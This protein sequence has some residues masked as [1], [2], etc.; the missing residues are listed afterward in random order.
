MNALPDC[1]APD[2]DRPADG[3]GPVEPLRENDSYRQLVQAVRARD[4]I[5]QIQIIDTCIR[6]T[7]GAEQAFWL[8]ARVD[9]QVRGLVAPRDLQ[10]AWGDLSTALDMAPDDPENQQAV[11]NSALMLAVATEEYHRL[12]PFMARL[13]PR[14]T[15]L[16]Q[17]EAFL[18]TLGLLYLKRRRW[19]LAYRTFT[20]AID[21]FRAMPPDRQ[22]ASEGRLI[23]LHANRAI[24]AAATGRVETAAMDVASAQTT[25]RKFMR[26][27]LN[28]LALALAQAELAFCS[29]RLQ[30]AR[31]ALQRGIMRVA[32]ARRR[33]WPNDQ[34]SF[35]ILAAR[36]ARAEGNMVGFS[37]FCNK[38]LELCAEHKLVVTGQT[39]RAVMAGA[40]R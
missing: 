15:P 12:A 8:R 5:R 13:R 34:V 6:E 24:V 4:H 11:L 36:L 19:D 20:N 39:V 17:H 14:G 32:A 33:L 21:A 29:G 37:H 30:D 16:V 2:L 23:Y 25:D 10:P 35:H 28:P 9:R 40:E 27:H 38:A 18:G 22:R 3:G 31:A 26:D 7:V 1:R